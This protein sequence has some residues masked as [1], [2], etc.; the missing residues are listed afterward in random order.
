MNIEFENDNG[1]PDSMLGNIKFKRLVS[2]H[3]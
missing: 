2:I 3:I 1:A